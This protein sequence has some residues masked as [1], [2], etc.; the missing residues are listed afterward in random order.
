VRGVYTPVNIPKEIIMTESELAVVITPLIVLAAWVIGMLLGTVI[1]ITCIG[2][3]YL[4][5]TVLKD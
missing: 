2:V 4:L 3:G 5:A 1:S